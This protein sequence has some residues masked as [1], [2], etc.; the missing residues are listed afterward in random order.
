MC[1]VFRAPLFGRERF[2]HGSSPNTSHAQLVK[3]AKPQT[4]DKGW[5]MKMFRGLEI[6]G[7]RG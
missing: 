6:Q 4:G 3:S 2:L 5:G 7:F 1:H